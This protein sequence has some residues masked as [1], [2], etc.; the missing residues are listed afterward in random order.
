M[1]G[2]TREEMDEEST[3]KWIPLKAYELSLTLSLSLFLLL[4]LFLFMSVYL[5]VCLFLSLSLSC[6]VGQAKSNSEP[7][8]Q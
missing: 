7:R 8:L 2:V 4:S 5:F 3:A 1:E 6:D